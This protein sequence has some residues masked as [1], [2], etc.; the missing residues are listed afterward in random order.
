MWIVF[1]KGTLILT[2]EAY[3]SKY[4]TCAYRRRTLRAIT[5]YRRPKVGKCPIWNTVN[6]FRTTKIEFSEE[7]LRYDNP[8]VFI[9]RLVCIVTLLCKQQDRDQTAS[10]SV[11]VML[12]SFFQEM[13]PFNEDSQA[14]ARYGEYFDWLC[15][16]SDIAEPDHDKLAKGV[17]KNLQRILAVIGKHSGRDQWKIFV[18]TEI[19]KEDK[20]G[21]KALSG[22][23]VDCAKYG[24]EFCEMKS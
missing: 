2:T 22:F 14:D 6:Q 11:H 1:G 17:V 15:V 13:L 7:Q 24:V 9:D 10:K 3:I 20:G 23:L 18:K 5:P 12:G 8:Y 4:Y 19:P 16:H 21:A